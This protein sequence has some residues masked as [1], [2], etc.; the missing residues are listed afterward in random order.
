M[1]IPATIAVALALAAP[2]PAFAGSPSYEVAGLPISRHQ[3]QATGL[4]GIAE[5]A[6]RSGPT[7]A[8]M[9]ASPHQLAVLRRSGEGERRPVA[10]ARPASGRD[11]GAARISAYSLPAATARVAAE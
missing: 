5:A 4:S 11:E 2:A 6:P 10:D 7:V 1:K 3:I 9:L 8:G